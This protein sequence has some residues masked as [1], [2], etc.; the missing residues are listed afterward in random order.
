MKPSLPTSAF[1]AFLVV[2]AVGVAASACRRHAATA[3]DCAD[4]LDHL[5]EVELAEAGYRDPILRARWKEDARRR[6]AAD[7]ARCTGLT[8]R[9][10]LKACL[11]SVTTTEEILHRCIEVDAR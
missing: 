11:R 7:L 9:D 5:V 2:L 8:V 10:D 4:V 6:Y 3:A 1:K